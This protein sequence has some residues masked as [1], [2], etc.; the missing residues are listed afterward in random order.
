MKLSRIHELR[1]VLSHERIGMSELSEIESAFA[2]L[3]PT[4]LSDSAENAMASDMLD[5]LEVR[6]S[7]SEKI[8]TAAHEGVEQEVWHLIGD[9]DDPYYAAMSFEWYEEQIAAIKA[10][11]FTVVDTP[12]TIGL[13]VS[14]SH[15]VTARRRLETIM[16]A[17]VMNNLPEQLSDTDPVGFT[18][19]ELLFAK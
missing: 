19:T 11:Q 7:L 10:A 1:T 6:V 14:R 17:A 4:T 9:R 12:Y 18:A 5:E 8:L 3:D 16:E 13:T 15:N 2:E